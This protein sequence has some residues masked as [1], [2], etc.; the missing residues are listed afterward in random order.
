LPATASAIAGKARAGQDPRDL[1]VAG[2]LASEVVAS[3]GLAEADV[4]TLAAANSHL[5]LRLHVY[6]FR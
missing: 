3:E 1:I 6:P 5:L 4:L 2:P